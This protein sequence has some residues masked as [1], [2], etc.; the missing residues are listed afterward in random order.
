[1][2]QNDNK[3][4]F[5]DR[6]LT[7]DLNIHKEHIREIVEAIPREQ[8]LATSV[9]TLCEYIVAKL[10]V[11]PLVLDEDQIRMEHEET[12]I[13]VTR[14]FEYGGSIS[15]NPVMVD[16]HLLKFYIPFSGSQDF[17]WARPNSFSLNP[18]HGEIDTSRNLLILFF[19]NT[20]QTEENWFKQQLESTLNKIR[21]CISA[22]LSQIQ[23]YNVS[24]PR[25]AHEAI[26][27]RR[28]QLAK[29][30]G[31]ISSFSIPLVK[32]HG[33]PEYSPIDI[34][35]RKQIQL[36]KVP[37][38]GFKP[39][40]AIT[41]ELYEAILANIRHMGA[42]FEGTPQTYKSLGED[43]LRDIILASLN[44]AYQGKA[45]GESFRHY[46][47]TDI[48]I[49]EGTRSA[50][51]AECKMWSGEKVLIEA[52]NQLLEYLTWRDCKAS[53]VI[54]NKTVSGF[55]GLQKTISAT[56]PAHELFLREK[57]GQPAGEWRCVCRSREDI[58][59]EITV[60]IFCFNLFVA[61]D[62]L[63]RKR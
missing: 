45:T 61:A 4:F 13:D 41:D 63:N 59:R 29:S 10:V 26:A 21:Q 11:D 48:R 33:M 44:S 57:S 9:D 37:Q 16:G 19:E 32:K 7:N 27:H 28:E 52:L 22:Q 51:V 58:E 15:S 23:Q 40:H 54:F 1:M 50:F 62:R 31:L 42:T 36:S 39:E 2:Y 38:T 17:W 5:S 20:T 55:S 60:H 49:E 6:E 24:L 3:C 8:F 43:G 53:I 14:R 35:P 25:L 30:H 12:K 46:G 34:S 47:K 18:P 56:L